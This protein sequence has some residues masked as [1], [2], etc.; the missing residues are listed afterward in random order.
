MPQLLIL[1][2]LP[3]LLFWQLCC[4]IITSSFAAIL[5]C[6]LGGSIYIHTWCVGWYGWC[7]D[8]IWM[9]CIVACLHCTDTI[10]GPRPTLFL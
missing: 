10:F 2:A 1:V 3:H 4:D 6:K 8:W 9:G 5:V 7:A